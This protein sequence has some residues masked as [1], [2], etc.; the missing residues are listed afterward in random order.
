MTCKFPEF[1]EKPESLTAET[2]TIASVMSKAR[3]SNSRAFS[4]FMDVQMTTFLS[5]ISNTK[6]FYADL[7]DNLCGD[8]SFAEQRDKKCWNGER[9]AE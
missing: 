3:Q 7:A 4:H 2:T 8:E 1:A 6:G 9:V 5:V